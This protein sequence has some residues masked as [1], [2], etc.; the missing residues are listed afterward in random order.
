MVK[1]YDV[2][3]TELIEKLAE[4]LKKT[5]GITPPEWAHYCKTGPNRERPPVQQDW[6]YLRSASVLIYVYEHG[7]IGVAKLRTRY[8]GRK[9]RGVKPERFYKSSGNILRKI[10]QQ[11]EAAGFLK[12]VEKGVHKGRIITPAG[13]SLVDKT[14]ATCVKKVEPVKKQNTAPVEPQKTTQK[15]VKTG[16]KKEVRE[17]KKVESSPKVQES[18]PLPSSPDQKSSE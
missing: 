5:K 18:T 14:A 12:H 11:Q 4:E 16:K 7:P 13:T 15:Q 1:S 17:Q 8:G 9:N 6:W 3:K 10:L 2:Q